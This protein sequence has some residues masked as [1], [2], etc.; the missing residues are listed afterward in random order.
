MS[1]EKKKI[2]FVVNPRSANGAT[3]RAWSSLAEKLRSRIGEF[4][5]LFTSRPMEAAA[6]TRRAL[7]DGADVVVAVGGDG[8]TNEVVNGFF[9]DGRVVREGAALAVFPR[10]TGGDFPKTWK[11]N[12]SVESTA[13]RLAAMRLA[14]L[15]IGRLSYTS[16]EGKPAQ[17]YFVNIASAGS[18]GLIDRYANEGSKALGGKLSFLIASARGMLAWRDRRCRIRLDEGAW[19][20]HDVTVLAVGNGQYFGG[21]MWVAPHA[22]PDDGKFGV[23]IWS[24]FGISDF[25]VHTRKIYDGRHVKLR[26]T[27]TREAKVVEATS[28]EEV[29]LDV[30][31]EAPGRLPAKW[32]V[33]PAAIRVVT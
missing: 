26:G 22:K 4:G 32:E 9:E 23:T 21:G 12:T 2:V 19:E 11:W 29:L 7:Q 33:L 28:D 27:T 15:D 8:T 18:S 5:A 1:V 3:G 31:G 24:G 14:P 16:H 25:V 17:R 20:E 6:L 30:D 13:A 10:G